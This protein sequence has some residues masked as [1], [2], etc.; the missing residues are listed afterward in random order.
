MR[1]V[2]AASVAVTAPKFSTVMRPRLQ[3]RCRRE[4]LRDNLAWLSGHRMRH[5]PRR[6]PIH[7]CSADRLA[8]TGHLDVDARRLRSSAAESCRR[9]ADRCQRRAAPERMT[10]VPDSS[11]AVIVGRCSAL[12][13]EEQTQE[14]H[15]QSGIGSRDAD[16]K[17]RSLRRR[18]RGR[19]RDQRDRFD[20]TR[21]LPVDVALPRRFLPEIEPRTLRDRLGRRVGFPDLAACRPL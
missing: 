11:Q 7:E 19:L 20:P 15:L 13:V 14:Q 3:W 8:I 12:I 10:C 2:S 17:N 5:L 1:I 18:R 21:A 9:S 4:R 16:A 6:H